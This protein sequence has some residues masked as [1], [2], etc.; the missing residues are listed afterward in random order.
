MLHDVGFGLKLLWR[1]KGFT[2]TAV[3]TLAL[4]LGANTAIFTVLN[5]VV[6]RP[7]PYPESARLVTMYNVYPGVGASGGGANGVPD[8]FDRRELK[9]VFEEVALIG[10]IGFD[11]GLE[12]APQHIRGE[13]VTHSYFRVLRTGAALGRTF[14]E[15]EC[16]EGK[17]GVAV[18]SHG[19]WKEMFAGDRNILGKTIRLSGVQHR[20]IGV[21][22]E[23][24]EALLREVRIW[25]PFGITPRQRSDDAR[26]SNNWGMI[27]R[28]K[29]GVSLELAQKRVDALN[30]QNLDRFP[31][32][33]RLLI[34]ARF[35]TRVRGLKS[36]M[37]REISA[38]LWMLQATVALVLLIGCVN[39]ANLMLVRS[40][41]RMKELAI[42][43]SLGAGRWRLARQLL[44]ESLL[45][46]AIGG[47][48]GLAVGAAGVPLLMRL[49]ASELPRAASIALDAQVLAFSAVTA[50]L[51]GLICGGVPV[52]HLFRRNLSD[53]FRQTER[54]GTAERRALWTR[55]A[56]VVSQVALAC[57]LLTGAGLLTLS[58]LRIL[59]VNPGFR[60]RNVATARIGLPRSRYTDDARARN[61]LARVVES[62][63]TLPGVT[64]A[65]LTTYLPFSGNNNASVIRIE[66]HVLAAGETPPVPGWNIA[67]GGY[68]QAL[69]IPLLRGRVF[70][71]ADGPEAPRVAVIDEFLARRYWPKGGELGA[72][73]LRSMDSRT[74]KPWTI[75]GVVGS[76]KTGNL[77]EHN[78]VGQVYF[79]YQQYTPRGVHLVVKT[80]RD[81]PRIA[82]ALRREVLRADAEM[83]LLDVKTMERRLADSVLDRSASMILTLAFA[84]LALVLSAVGIYG[85]L[86]YSV[87]QRTR[88]FGIRVALGAA[89]SDVLRMVLMQGIK[90]AAAGLAIGICGA[91]WMTRLVAAMLYDVKPNHPGVFLA[92]AASLAAVALAASLLPSL[93]AVRIR[94]AVALRYE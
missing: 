12:G 89:S 33:R 14:T 54:A 35:A 52:F 92:V 29:P 45:V 86:A 17:A 93:R 5:P 58:F 70:T 7:L 53:V 38:T 21:M 25:T 6:L 75:V 19:L 73:L 46:A 79:P 40:N 37:M 57:V 71:P 72:R 11:V 77:A 44:T 15:D 4:C 64:A 34:D 48:F 18:L 13:Y 87:T 1:E 67:D 80:L 47:V 30:Q 84:G 28:L 90:L 22:P 55:S 82:E 49:G 27:A 43:F 65:G 85:V 74:E 91:Y 56:L 23:S 24:F 16:V 2:A 3:I 32:F 60:A 69:G 66:G 88:E 10:G 51:T 41:V 59:S 61:L 76:V 68:F 50:L 63:R 83:P 42:R 31:R 9:D 78:P 36:E 94:P 26:H 62:A 8:Y 81:E 20:I 39:V